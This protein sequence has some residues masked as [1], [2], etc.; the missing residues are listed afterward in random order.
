M[1]ILAIYSVN[2]HIADLMAEAANQR[3]I[4]E[5]KAAKGT[6]SRF[7]F[8]TSRFSGRTP[9]VAATAPNKALAGS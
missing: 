1:H 2:E 6:R 4:N 7:A 9:A 8:L 3:L 5:A